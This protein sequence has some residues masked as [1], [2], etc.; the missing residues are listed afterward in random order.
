MS[1]GNSTDYPRAVVR[2]IGGQ[3]VLDDPDA[4][5]MIRGVGKVN[6]R[7][8]FEINT[9]RVAHFKCRFAERG[10]ST[11]EGVIVLINV[12]DV[13]GGTTRGCANARYRLAGDS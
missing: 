12:N 1:K 5:E 6:C 2:E 8:T 11:E 4:L 7:N 13:N 9:E 10:M 3:L